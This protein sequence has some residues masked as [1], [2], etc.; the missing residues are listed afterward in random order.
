[1]VVKANN[2]CEGFKTYEDVLN[3]INKTYGKAGIDAYELCLDLFEQET[4]INAHNLKGKLVFTRYDKGP[5]PATSVANTKPAMYIKMIESG[6]ISAL[7]LLMK[8]YY[9]MVGDPKLNI[10]RLK[11]ES[12]DNSIRHKGGNNM[13]KKIQINENQVDEAR[14]MHTWN[15]TYTGKGNKPKT[16]MVDAPDAYEA[17]RKA[18][19]ELGIAYTDIDDVTMVENKEAVNEAINTDNFKDNL[20][21][22]YNTLE[23][24]D[25]YIENNELTIT[26][27]NYLVRYGE[28][29]SYFANK[30]LNMVEL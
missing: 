16:H 19:R 30:Y 12:I 9:N 5:V 29:I 24:L 28:M 27:L 2:I 21:T 7:K 23:A 4:G 20:E 18:R 15:I 8:Y 17:N 22:I 6:E 11:K 25:D 3:A 26:E 14:Q 10:N 13:I 1:M